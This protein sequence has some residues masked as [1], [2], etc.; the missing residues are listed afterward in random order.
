MASSAY[1]AYPAVMRGLRETK[2]AGTAQAIVDAAMELLRG[3]HFSDVSVDEIVAAARIGRRTFFRYFPT[4]EDVLLDRRRIDRA[5]AMAALRDR[6]PGEDDVA[7]LM[8]VLVEIQR[9]GFAAFKPEHQLELHRLSHSEPELAA[10]SWLLMEEVRDILVAGLAG[11]D[12]GR[13]E[14]L[15]ARVLASACIMV[16]DAGITTW[17]EGGMRDDLSVILAEGAEHLRTGYG[18]RADPDSRDVTPWDGQPV[19]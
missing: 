7:L 12:P 9:R 19:S 4:K 14:L 6:S 2:K 11:P 13:S 3:R 8:R 10:R 18:R 1:F 17:I 5:Y 15:R 16:V